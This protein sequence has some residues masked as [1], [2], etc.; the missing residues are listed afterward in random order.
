MDPADG[1]HDALRWANRAHQILGPRGWHR[2]PHRNVCGRC[3][4]NGAVRIAY[5]Y[6]Y[7]NGDANT[8]TNSDAYAYPETYSD[9]EVSSGAGTSPD[10]AAV[11]GMVISDQQSVN[12]FRIEPLH[13]TQKSKG[14]R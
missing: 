11:K 1:G 8:N 14:I 12:G 13:V 6:A 10:A 3:A 7:S 9:T 2:R 4:V 5:T